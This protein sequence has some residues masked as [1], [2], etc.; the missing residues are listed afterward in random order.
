MQRCGIE[1]Q[2]QNALD[3]MECDDN[4]YYERTHTHKSGNVIFVCIIIMYIH[5]KRIIHSECL[6]CYC[7]WCVLCVW[8]RDVPMYVR[9]K[10]A[11]DWV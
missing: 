10:R 5:D 9:A 3:Q 8:A 1:N 4:V 7:G 6:L 2:N 11:S